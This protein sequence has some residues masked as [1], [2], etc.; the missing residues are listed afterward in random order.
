MSSEPDPSP[1]R[2]TF[3]VFVDHEGDVYLTLGKGATYRDGGEVKPIRVDRPVSRQTLHTAQLVLVRQVVGE[4]EA[5]GA[6]RA[7]AEA[8]DDRAAA[9]RAA[10]QEIEATLH[11]MQAAGI[12]VRAKHVA[13]SIVVVV[14]AALLGLSVISILY[15]GIQWSSEHLPEWLHIVVL[16]LYSVG[17][18]YCISL[19]ATER[20]RVEYSAKIRELFGLRGMIIL[21]LLIV[22]VAGTIFASITLILYDHGLVVLWPHGSKAVSSESLLYFYM[23][24]FWKLVPLL[25][26]N[27]VLSWTEPF[28]YSQAR[29]G[30]LIL[31]YQAFVVI[32]SI[33]TVRFYWKH[34]RGLERDRVEYLYEPGWSPE[35]NE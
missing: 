14:L 15:Q 24:H 11:P 13:K 1:P 9:R 2:L 12:R 4:L 33:G 3:H 27:D 10:R 22:V 16:A 19:I 20:S 35:G 31:L 18:I 23:W 32:P 29:I 28:S 26:I 8:R 7:A 34:R 17:L 6:E 5:R 21:P 30:F 25:R